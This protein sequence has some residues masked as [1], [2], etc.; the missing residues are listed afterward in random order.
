LAAG[1]DRGWR[2]AGAGAGAGARARG[3][4]DGVGGKTGETIQKCVA[5]V[6]GATGP[7][8]ALMYSVSAALLNYDILGNRLFNLVGGE[9]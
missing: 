6:S 8:V 4:H 7:T 2:G 3:G 1:R 5:F 9:E